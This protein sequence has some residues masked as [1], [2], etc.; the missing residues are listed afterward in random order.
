[1]GR[2]M[3]SRLVERGFR[4]AV[5]DFD[6]ANRAPLVARGATPKADVAELGASADLVFATIPHDGALESVVFGG[7]GAKGLVDARPLPSA[8][9]EMSTV[10]PAASARIASVLAE[11]GIAYLRAP[12]SGSTDMARDGKLTVLASGDAATWDRAVEVFDVLAARRFYLGEGEQ[13]RFMKLVLNTLVGATSAVLSEAMLLGEAGGL[14]RA[15]IMDVVGQSAVASPLLAYKRAA[16]V[17]DDF[18]PA[19]SVEQMIKDFTLICGAANR[20]GL[21]MFATGLILQQYHAAAAAGYRDADFFALMNWLRAIVD[22]GNREGGREPSHQVIET[23]VEPGRPGA[24]SAL[25]P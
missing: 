9:I 15:Q 13:A 11:A 3:A 1:M 2:P 25:A 5:C 23:T 4:V 17:E 21:P 12:V 7:D 19:F 16:I 22:L 6:P 8:L 14:S 10:S 24:E 18:T 20:E